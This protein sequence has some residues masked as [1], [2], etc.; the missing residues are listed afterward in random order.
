M[1]GMASGASSSAAARVGVVTVSFGSEGVLPTML[2]SLPAAFDGPIETVV[3]DNS[4]QGDAVAELAASHRARYLP[5]PDNP[6]YGGAM[7]AGVALLGDGVEWVLI[8]NPDLVLTPGSITRLL[9]RGESD[10]SIAAVGP[11][12]RELDGTVYPSARAVPSLR[13]GVGHALFVNLWPTNPWSASYRDDSPGT[14]VLKDAGWLS[15]SCLLV[16]RSAFD[17]I[18]G[19]DERF[20]MYF[21]DVDLGFRFGKSGM[22]NVYDPAAEVTHS[23]AH[24][25]GR[26]TSGMIRAHHASARLFIQ[27]KYPGPVLWPVRTALAIGLRLRSDLITRRLDRAAR[28]ERLET[29]P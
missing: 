15:G 1:G 2:A 8:A 6:G 12:V 25:T 27:R 3:V 21:E 17:A 22:R 7:N 9:E 28:T 13:T 20:F 10:P 29:S 11:L 5:R 26:D 14:P 19:F 16:R 24:A 4:P 23:G 18:G